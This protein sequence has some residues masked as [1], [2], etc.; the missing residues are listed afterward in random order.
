MVQD[1]TEVSILDERDPLSLINA[2]PAK[3]REMVRAC[4]ARDP[5]FF[6]L[7]EDQIIALA[8]LEGFHFNSTDHILRAQFWLEFNASRSTTGYK[9]VMARV[10]AGTIS[11]EGFYA[12]F[13][14][15]PPRVAFMFTMPVDYQRILEKNLV[16]LA[17]NMAVIIEQPLIDPVSKKFDK[18][19]AQ[20]QINL[21][22]HHEVT[23]HGSPTQRIENKTLA[24]HI[25][26]RKARE[27]AGAVEGTRDTQL[28]SRVKELESRLR[29]ATHVPKPAEWQSQ[30]VTGR[31]AKDVTVSMKSPPAPSPKD[32]E[33]G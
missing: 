7:E 24:L 13:L 27:L 2:V 20:M 22:K 32:P 18:S 17:R 28:A 5:R 25:G 15:S 19:L 9:M 3:V 8:K 1:E 4:Q 31:D 21:L 12:H 6:G 33:D 29:A 10:L 26:G 30:P 11:S 23:L 14:K 16:L